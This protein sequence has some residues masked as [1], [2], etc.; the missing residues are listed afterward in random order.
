MLHNTKIPGTRGYNTNFG[1]SFLRH[2]TGLRDG[3]RIKNKASNIAHWCLVVNT[4]SVMPCDVQ[5]ASRALGT[6]TTS[7]ELAA[8]SIGFEISLGLELN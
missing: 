4:I 8:I 1:T 3:L 6:G 2:R 7:K 5:L